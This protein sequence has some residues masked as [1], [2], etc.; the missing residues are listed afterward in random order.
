MKFA[1]T[2][3]E[4]MR[5]QYASE[6]VAKVTH[7]KDIP[8]FGNIVAIGIT[9]AAGRVYV[10]SCIVVGKK[11]KGVIGHHVKFRRNDSNPN[12]FITVEWSKAK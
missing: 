3:R 7:Y 11:L 12:G 10:G 6:L 2:L 9:D 1:G 8:D 5:G 4:Y